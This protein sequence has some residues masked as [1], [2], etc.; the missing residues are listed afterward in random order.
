V[1]FRFNNK[2][3][4]PCIGVYT[5]DGHVAG[6]YGRLGSQPLI[7]GKAQDI[8]VLVHADSKNHFPQE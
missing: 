5:V 1:P 4:F 3:Y 7:N 8:A 2:D 6:A